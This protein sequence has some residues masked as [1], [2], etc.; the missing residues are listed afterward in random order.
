ML[1]KT[2]LTVVLK[3]RN[4]T[5]KI[6][7]LCLD[8]GRCF[9][10]ADPKLGLQNA[11]IAE[12]VE[13]TIRPY[14][15]VEVVVPAYCLNKYRKM[16]DEQRANITQYVLDRVPDGQNAVWAMLDKPAV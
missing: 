11:A 9:E 16:K 1:Q 4:P 8:R 15:T 6:Q 12:R 5:D 2:L 3:V 13:R 10:I 7:T 14:Q